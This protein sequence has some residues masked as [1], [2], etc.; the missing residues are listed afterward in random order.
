MVPQ[1]S[2]LELK[3]NLLLEAN[4]SISTIS[5]IL[6]KPRE[7]IYNTIKRINRKKQANNSILNRVKKGRIDK[8]SPREKRAIN[9]DLTRSPKKENKRLL[10]EN[11]LEISKRTL[12]RF[13]K[14]EDYSINVAT[15]KQILNA[16]KA[17][18]RN[19]Y[20]KNELKKKEINFNKVIFLDEC[21]IQRGHGSRAEY[22]RKKRNKKL[23][24][25]LISSYSTS[26]F[27]TTFFILK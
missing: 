21:S 8:L 16:K 22:I 11:N 18:N 19:T 24:K 1:L 4:T 6:K 25:E 2:D 20:A 17:K 27:S 23:R 15:K 26:K 7:S 10:F 13:L 14:E 9:R 3:V 5:T 12:Q